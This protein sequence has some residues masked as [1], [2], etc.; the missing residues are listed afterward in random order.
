[1]MYLKTRAIVLLWWHLDRKNLLLSLA[2]LQVGLLVQRIPARPVTGNQTPR[3][4]SF[5]SLCIPTKDKILKQMG[6]W[7][8]N[9]N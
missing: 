2:L 5:K 6:S 8:D 3:Q 4:V 1:M 9:S 7:I